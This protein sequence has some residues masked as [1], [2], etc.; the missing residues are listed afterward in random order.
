MKKNEVMNL[1]KQIIKIDR[2]IQKIRKKLINSKVKQH[3]DNKNL[4]KLYHNNL[5]IQ[6]SWKIFYDKINRNIINRIRF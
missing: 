3:N 6:E 2:G 1:Q 4:K 5:K